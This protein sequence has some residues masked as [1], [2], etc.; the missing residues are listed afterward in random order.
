MS[1]NPVRFAITS[2]S[3]KC[4]TYTA[5]DLDEGVIRFWR[6]SRATSREDAALGIESWPYRVT[7]LPG[8]SAALQFEPRLYVE[9]T[10]GI[11]LTGEEKAEIGAQLGE[12]VDIVQG[13]EPRA[14]RPSAKRAHDGFIIDDTFLGF[15]FR[16]ELYIECGDERPPVIIDNTL[17]FAVSP[18]YCAFTDMIH[19][20]FHLA[21]Y[22]ETVAWN[23]RMSDAARKSLVEE[24]LGGDIDLIADILIHGRGALIALLVEVGK[25]QGLVYDFSE[26]DEYM[27]SCGRSALR[28]FRRHSANHCIELFGPVLPSNSPS[29]ENNSR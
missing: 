4:A 28:G 11:T 22:S 16:E 26:P 1:G 20:R 24:A 29:L 27:V 9:R 17:S 14:P 23:R 10:I 25:D 5:G 18:S 7:W 12:L 13:K 8:L 2:Y 21:A 19:D 3:S 15:D 6:Y